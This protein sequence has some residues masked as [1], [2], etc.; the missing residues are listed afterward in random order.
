MN[1]IKSLKLSGNALKVLQSRYLLHQHGLEETP[2]QLFRR[3][4]KAVASAE[5][6][7]GTNQ[8]AA[9]WENDFFKII[10]NLLFLPNS[11]TLMNAGTPLNQLSACFV[12]PVED[13]LDQIFTSLK[14]AAIIQQSGG[15]TGFNFSHLRP[16][17]DP[18]T[19]TQ[20]TA[21]GPVSFRKYLMQPQKISGMGEREGALTWAYSISTTRTLKNSFNQR[22]K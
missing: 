15:G 22:K 16:K 18:L 11:P 5:L 1:T 21:S 2:E 10:A 19:I 6:K 17:D 12:L 4:A 3:V 9:R 7:W 13:S 14:N 8:D 20:G